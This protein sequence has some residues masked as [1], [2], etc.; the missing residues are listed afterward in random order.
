[1]MKRF[2]IGILLLGVLTGC[3]YDKYAPESCL[4]EEEEALYLSFLL[5]SQGD[6]M[7]TKASAGSFSKQAI[8]EQLVSRVDIYF[9][10]LDGNYLDHKY[11]PSTEE[12][13]QG[14][15]QEG[16][17]P[18]GD[19]A[20]GNIANR[21]GQFYVKLTKYRPA[22]MVLAMN[23][24]SSV[25]GSFENKKL[26]DLRGEKQA[27]SEKWAGS[28]IVIK[29]PDSESGASSANVEP[30]FMTS[31]TYLSP[32]GVEMCD[33]LIPAS[34]LQETSAKA[35]GRPIPVY[36][37]RLAAKVMVKAPTKEYPVPIVTRYPGIK[38]KVNILSWSLNGLNRSSYYYKKV[39]QSWD[40]NWTG[41]PWNEP[42]KYRSHWSQDPN[43]TGGVYPKDYG[44]FKDGT[45]A[46]DDRDLDYV[47]WGE[48]LDPPADNFTTPT[49]ENAQYCLENT[50]DKSILSKEIAKNEL[51]PRITHVLIK[52]KLSFD[53]GT[54]MDAAKD[55]DGYK[56][57]TEL[58]RYKGVY[59]TKTGLVQVQLEEMADADVNNVYYTDNTATTPVTAANFD[60]EHIYGEHVYLKPKVP[61]Y[62]KVGTQ[63]GED[64]LKG[65]KADGFN[66]GYFYYKVPIEHLTAE[67]K[68]AAYYPTAQYGVVRNHN[69]VITLGDELGGIGTGVWD[70]TE[71]IVP[72]TEDR[73][74]V[75]SVHVTVSNW[76]QFETHFVLVDPS[77]MLVTNGHAL[78]MWED[79]GDPSK[80][81]YNDWT[82]NGWYF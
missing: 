6:L 35:L 16:L 39:N 1:M 3:I 82:G 68:T 31:S 5:N 41:L 21:V 70:V 66:N 55:V 36:V 80:E 42:A 38:A 22:R 56:S 7:S 12:G 61:V 52:A 51:Y 19:D 17:T 74:Y 63:Q 27:K 33:I 77:G 40:F 18:D 34:Y 8:A 72:V 57:A 2:F 48:T 53:Y 81:G 11:V 30:F 43:Y 4:G 29:Y 76:K 59:Y 14:F 9:Y 32:T 54:G 65:K 58:F 26:S 73:D 10:D 13:L 15:S 24:S 64:F 23:L 28:S 71:P 25:A 75:V 37:E 69:Y 20:G 45:I 79:E 50:A 47:K 60:I 67:D 49:V 62:N 46:W 44:N 78:R